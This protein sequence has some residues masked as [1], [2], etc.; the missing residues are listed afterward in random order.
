SLVSVS[1]VTDIETWTSAGANPVT[2]TA[3]NV[4]GQMPA[5]FSGGFALVYSSTPAAATTSNFS[6]TVTD[7]SPAPGPYSIVVPV[8]VVVNA[9]KFGTSNDANNKLWR[10]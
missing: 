1:A 10:E 9:F 8:S 6:V 4:A 7:T 3:P 2:F 5:T